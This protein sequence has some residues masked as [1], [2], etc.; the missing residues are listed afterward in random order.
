[1]DKKDNSQPKIDTLEEKEDLT[2]FQ[3]DGVSDMLGKILMELLY[4]P[5]D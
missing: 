5:T 1:M 2:N 4:N 3:L